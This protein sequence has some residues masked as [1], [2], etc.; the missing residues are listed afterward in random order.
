[1]N[2]GHICL[3]HKSVCT[4]FFSANKHKAANLPHSAQREHAF[5]F[6]NSE[7]K[8]HKNKMSIESLHYRLG[9]SYTR[10]LLAGYTDNVWQYIEL[11]VYPDPFCTSCRIS[12]INKSLYKN[13]H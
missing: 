1:M 9:H 4:F 3:F 10:S 5:F 6:F 11:R 13:K 8:I 7:I 12:T 2:L